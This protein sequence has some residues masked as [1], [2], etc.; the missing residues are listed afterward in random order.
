MPGCKFRFQNSKTAATL[1]KILQGGRKEGGSGAP[2]GTLKGL[3][4]LRCLAVNFGYVQNCLAL[5]N[6]TQ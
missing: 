2:V 1:L 5:V 3:N 4:S 6:T